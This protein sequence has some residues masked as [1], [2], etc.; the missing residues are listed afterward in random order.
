MSC[1]A[2]IVT[3]PIGAVPGFF[4]TTECGAQSFKRI[5]V[6]DGDAEML[7]CSRC[8][9]RFISKASTNG[10]SVK[11]WLG[12]FDCDIPPLAPIH[13]SR[14][15]WATVTEAYLAE[16]P[17]AECKSFQLTPGFMNRWLASKKPLPPSTASSSPS[18]T[19]SSSTASSPV[20]P[21]P[22]PSPPSPSPRQEIETEI[23]Q[24]YASLNG[25]KT[26]LKEQMEIHRKIYA[27]KVKLKLLK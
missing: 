26:K 16:N 13:G 22:S 19:A 14:R 4:D 25:V 6:D 21:S 17:T 11:G 8:F 5:S 20:A 15:F 27:L 23:A 18:S 9:V 7:I 10:E 2:R 3:T 24:L 1:Q 12:W